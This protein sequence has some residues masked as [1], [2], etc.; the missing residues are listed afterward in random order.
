M[1][2]VHL[3]VVLL[4][5]ETVML[6]VFLTAITVL[7]SKHHALAIKVERQ[8]AIGELGLSMTDLQRLFDRMASLEGQL[9]TALQMMQTIHTH[10]LEAES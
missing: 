4:L 9:K 7:W 8:K 5:V 6:L 2:Q 10:L 1:N 3:I